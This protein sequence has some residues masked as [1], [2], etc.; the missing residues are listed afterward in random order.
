ME[1]KLKKQSGGRGQF[2][3]CY[4][5]VEPAERGSGVQ[6]VDEIVGGA[7]PRQYIPAVEKGVLET[8]QIG[9]IAGYPLTDIIVR[10]VDGK[11]H[12]VDSSEQSFKIA[13]SIGLKAAIQ[14]AKPTL[15]EPIMDLEVSIP[16]EFVGDIMGNLNS[17]RGR[18]AGVESRGSMQMVKAQVPM[19]ET[20]SYAAD[21]TSMTGGQ[22][23]FRMEFLRYE[24]APAQVR[25]KVIADA[26]KEKGD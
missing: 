18:V 19:A 21:L 24:E 15:L 7:I 8:C 16:D 6:F 12:S 26:Q 1:G 13:A 23:S 11:H 2:G 25:E 5:T 9:V 10:C 3:V 4:L 22:G 17:R 14:Q 20:L